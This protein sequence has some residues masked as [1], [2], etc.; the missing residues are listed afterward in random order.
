MRKI[1]GGALLSIGEFIVAASWLSGI[2]L[3][4]YT[5]IFAYGVSGFLAAFITLIFPVGAQI[6]WVIATWSKTGDFVNGFSFYVMVYLAW[7]IA[8]FLISFMGVAIK[9]KS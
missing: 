7:L 9:P 3:H 4:L 1:I 5:I 2:S 8:G 6:Y